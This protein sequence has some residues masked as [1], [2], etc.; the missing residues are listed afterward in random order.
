M[1]SDI[2]RKNRHV[3]WDCVPTVEEL[4]RLRKVAVGDARGDVIIR[5]GRSIPARSSNATS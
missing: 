3:G 1:T 2:V 5:G 4:M